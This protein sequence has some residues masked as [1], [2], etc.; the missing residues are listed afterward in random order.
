V[1]ALDAAT[2]ASVWERD[3]GDPA[4]HT[5]L[6]CGNID[7]LGVTGTP[8]IDLGTRTV[9]LDA[10]TK[11]AGAPRHLVHALSLDDGAERAGFPID[12]A[13]TIT[14]GGVAFDAV[15]QNQRGALAIVG[16]VLHVPYGGH[17]GDC[18]DYRGWLVAVPLA[19]P[20]AAKAWATSA[21][22]GGTWAPSG[23]AS[24][25]ASVFIATGNTF[26]AASWSGGEAIVRFGPGLAFAGESKQF[27]APTDWKALD[28]GD[29]DIGGA[30][31]VLFDLAGSTPSRLALALG[32]NKKAYLLDR[33]DLGGV[34]DGV[35]QAIVAGD[36]I[37]GAATV[38]TT[39]KGTYFAFKGPGAGCPGGAA[40][41]LAAVRVKPGAPP[42]MAV[43]WCAVQHGLGSPM[44]TTTDGHADAIV[45][46]LGSEG[47]QRLHGFDA[48]TG[49]VVFAGGGDGDALASIRRY[50]TPIAAKGRI[51]VA[52]DG[53]VAAFAPG[54]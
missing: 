19:D 24:D 22:G 35:A 12:V 27:F 20:G 45:W 48:D 50:A 46:G 17:W 4:L 29:V 16:G 9:Y 53:E 37:I 30:G 31:P 13:A 8:A 25:G 49:A 39:T 33:D 2:G 44:V 10:M 54:P 14:A 47:D 3:L 38:Y 21:R 52:G 40:G 23:V 34:G 51:Y 43:A 36:E 41:D 32:K 18:G 11:V 26:G 7:P 1:H 28:A 5:D 15:V 42:S 6:P